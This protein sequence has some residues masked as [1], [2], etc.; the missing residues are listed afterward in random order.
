V[1]DYSLLERNESRISE[2]PKGNVYSI[3]DTTQAVASGVVG[4]SYGTIWL[5]VVVFMALQSVLRTTKLLRLVVV[6]HRVI[7]I[8]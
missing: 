2:T 8:N 5:L 6:G 7:Y 3:A 1:R 4:A